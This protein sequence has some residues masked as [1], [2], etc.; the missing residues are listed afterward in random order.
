MSKKVFINL[1]NHNSGAWSAAQF[2]AAS[3]YGDIVDVAFP[4]IAPCSSSEEIDAIVDQYYEKLMSYDLAAVMLQGE[5]VFTYRLVSRLKET[6]VTVLA[7]SS[8]RK[9]TEK[10]MPDG[11]TRKNS[12]FEFVM[13]MEY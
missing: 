6:E 12:V 3:A 1:S 13:F 5:Y 4:D 2:N 8:E 10:R 7:S 11:T 9:V